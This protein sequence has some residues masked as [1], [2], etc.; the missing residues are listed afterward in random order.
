MCD[1]YRENLDNEN[2]SFIYL[3]FSDIYQIALHDKKNE[4]KRY[5]QHNVANTFHN[6][7]F[8]VQI[9]GLL[10]SKTP[11]ILYVFMKKNY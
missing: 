10:Y 11:D 2:C 8:G 7:T 5:S 1:V 9:Y 4:R 6:V 3:K